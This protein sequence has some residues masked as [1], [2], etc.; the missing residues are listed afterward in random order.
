MKHARDPKQDEGH[1]PAEPIGDQPAGDQPGHCADR[2]AERE[3]AHRAGKLFAAEIVRQQR[4]PCGSAARLANADS[5]TEREQRPETC[6][7]AAQHGHYAPQRERARND[8][9]ARGAIGEPGERKSE[10]D[11]EQR[12]RH[13]G[14][15]AKLAVI[16]RERAL[17]ILQQ[18]RQHQP[19]SHAEQAGQG[20]CGKYVPA[21]TG[22]LVRAG[23]RRFSD[24]GGH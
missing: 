24:A 12:E 6:R 14:K 17:D 18:D 19:V 8:R 23:F 9:L 21:I 3:E 13:P 4:L 5:D 16:Q 20:Q 7:R 1:A 22:V 11:V 15:Q 10:G 2:R